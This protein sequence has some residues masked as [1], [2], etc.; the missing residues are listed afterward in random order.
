M[1]DDFSSKLY[2]FAKIASFP[3]FWETETENKWK[4]TLNFEKYFSKEECIPQSLIL[5]IKLH[6]L[7]K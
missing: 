3:A 7:Q 1:A 5:L 6:F 4:K 2:L